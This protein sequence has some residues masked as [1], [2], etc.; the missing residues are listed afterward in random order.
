M[1]SQPNLTGKENVFDQDEVI[2]T[3]TDILGH[4]TYA[5]RTFL[6]IS[7]YTEDEVIGKPHNII[8]HPD[9]PR[10]MF[11]MLWET[12]TTGHEMFAYVLNRTRLG[13]HYWVVAHVT[14]SL[15]AERAV[16][17]YHSNRRVPDRS[18]LDQV[19]RPLYQSLIALERSVADPDAGLD[20]S[21]R[22]LAKMLQDKGVSYE[23]YIFSL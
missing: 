8:R 1:K 7:E 12:L 21:S 17:G 23:K 15:N 2:V 22:A 5:N 11:K 4:I 6:T 19:I 9:M 3:K 10:C 20:A 14:P 13:N 16:V 18:I